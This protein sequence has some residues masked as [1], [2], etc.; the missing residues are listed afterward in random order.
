MNV[1]LPKRE[2]EAEARPAWLGLYKLGGIASIIGGALTIADIMVY[3]IWPQPTTIQG[4]FALFQKNPVVGLL[5][6]D[7]LGMIVYVI[8]IPAIIA[9]YVSLRR[10]SQ[11][12]AAFGAVLT[13]VGMAAYFASNTGVSML[14]LSSQYAAATTDAQ[15]AMFLAAGEAVLAIFQGPAFTTSFLLVS[16]ALLITA[17]VM[18]RSEVFSKRIACIGIIASVAGLTENFLPS[19]EIVILV[20]ALLNAIGL[21]IWFILIGRHLLRWSRRVL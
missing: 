11:S 18:F 6:Y 7:L 14:S 12:W 10:T 20:V 3:V 2:L 19:S 5:D 9:L 21:G 1:G 16:L 13:F 8:I 4:W 15:R 17:V